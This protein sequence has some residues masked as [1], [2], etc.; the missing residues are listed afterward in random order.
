MHNDK[1][2]TVINIM[3]DYREYLKKEDLNF[4]NNRNYFYTV[5][6][7][8]INYKLTLKY[9]DRNKLKNIL[10]YKNEKDT[11]DIVDKYFLKFYNINTK[12]I[13]YNK[14][15]AKTKT[16]SKCI[17]KDGKKEI[18]ILINNNIQDA[19]VI[20]HEFRHYLNMNVEDSDKKSN[21]LDCLTES[22]SIFEE[23]NIANYLKNEKNVLRTE[24]NLLLKLIFVRNYTIAKKNMFFYRLDQIINDDSSINKEN[25]K[26]IYYKKQ[27]LSKDIDSFLHL[28]N[29]KG[30]NFNIMI[31]YN[32]GT[33][34]ATA[35]HQ[36]IDSKIIDYSN[37]QKLDKI[38]YKSQDFKILD[39]VKININD[40]DHLFNLYKKEL[41]NIF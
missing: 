41:D 39:I 38:L 8:I 40:L 33:I 20:A 30:F 6:S 37:I 19:L 10:S 4:Y 27:K 15:P 32:I 2:N 1:L 23:I 29:T 16:N 26:K 7:K 18:K 25:Y 28:Y 14:L 24:I 31:W 34:L 9:I 17:I 3:Q 5:L 36:N 12:E 11:R 21:V 22:I 35:I 13:V